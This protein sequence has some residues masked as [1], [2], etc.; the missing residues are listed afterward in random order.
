MLSKSFFQG[1]RVVIPL[2]VTVCVMYWAGALLEA[3][4]GRWIK[5]LLPDTLA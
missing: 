2:A 5:L 4:M 1:L 3:L